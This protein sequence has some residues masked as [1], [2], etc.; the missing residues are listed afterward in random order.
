VR[1]YLAER[2]AVLLAT[3]RWCASTGYDRQI[4]GLQ[5]GMHREYVLLQLIAWSLA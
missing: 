2:F 1:D 4:G 3:S 5:V